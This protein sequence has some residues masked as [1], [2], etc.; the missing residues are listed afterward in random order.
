MKKCDTP[1]WYHDRKNGQGKDCP[2]QINKLRNKTAYEK[3]VFKSSSLG[4]DYMSNDE[5]FQYLESLMTKVETNMMTGIKEARKSYLYIISKKI[6]DEVYYKLG[7]SEKSNLS[8]IVGAQ[9]FL[10]P[11]LGDNVGFQV[12][13][14]LTFAPENIG[15]SDQQVAFYVE[16][17]CH[18]ILRFYFVSSNITF[19]NDQESEWYMIPETYGVYFCGF[20]LDVIATFAYRSKTLKK[21]LSPQNIWILSKKKPIQELKLPPEEDVGRRLRKD[22]RYDQVMDVFDHFGLRNIRDFGNRLTVKIQPSGKEQ[23]RG[24]KELFVSTLLGS[25]GEPMTYMIPDGNVEFVLLK[26]IKNQNKF[27][28][29]QPLQSGEIY[30]VVR[31]ENE[32]KDE[33]DKPTFRSIC[34]KKK[35]FLIPYTTDSTGAFI[36]FCIHIGD[37]LEI[38]KPKE[39]ESWNL[40]QQYE[41]YYNRKRVAKTTKTFT[42]NQNFVAPKWYFQEGIQQRFARKF[43]REANDARKQ[44]K[45]WEHSDSSLDVDGDNSIVYTWNLNG[46]SILKQELHEDDKNNTIRSA[47]YVVRTRPEGNTTVTEEVPV[48]RLMHLRKVQE[49][50]LDSEVKTTKFPGDKYVEIREDLVL[51]ENDHICL[52]KGLLFQSLEDNDFDKTKLLFIVRDI[53]SKR[54]QDSEEMVYVRGRIKFPLEEVTDELH[55]IM[56]PDMKVHAN[57]I[58]KVEA[59]RLKVGQVIKAKPSLVKDFGEGNTSETQYHY[60]KIVEV[61]IEYDFLYEIQYFPPFDKIEPWNIPLNDKQALKLGKHTNPKDKRLELWK[62]DLLEGTNVHVVNNT[63]SLEKK[64]L[65]TYKTKLMK[66]QQPVERVLSHL[67][68]KA[69]T[70]KDTKEY[71][72]VFEN[73]SKGKIPAKE[74]P[75]ELETAY[76][77]KRSATKTRKKQQKT[78]NKAKNQTERRKT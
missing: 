32:K 63:K 69:S 68:V 43:L 61:K 48:V 65:E 45:V 27:G 76:W 49:T 16:Q 54:F 29:G 5:V 17:M 18:K 46:Q 60:A 44:N 25:S 41:Y 6:G 52:P 78:K 59:P 14:I 34:D 15:T 56:I 72:V 58:E 40:R 23:F 9:T 64:Q 11:G 67:P 39:T 26:I 8:R 42:I 10:I 19:G 47:V 35:I 74:L 50:D 51:K 30:G 13:M 37:L 36:E 77:G 66:F 75:S 70:M 4:R 22:D 53:Y 20:I 1:I 62:R 3:T 57:K 55:V 71:H 33:N 38:L 12:H 24:S 31:N 21:S 2:L 28:V 7:L 73:R